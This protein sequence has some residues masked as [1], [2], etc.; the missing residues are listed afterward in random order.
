MAILSQ[1]KDLMYL[2]KNYKYDRTPQSEP[3][4]LIPSCYDNPNE[5]NESYFHSTLAKSCLDQDSAMIGAIDMV[6]KHH[7]S[8][9]HAG[10]DIKLDIITGLRVF[11]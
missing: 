5:P 4:P 3:F 6:E 2:M 9:F 11:V 7:V 8:F 1:D 10:G